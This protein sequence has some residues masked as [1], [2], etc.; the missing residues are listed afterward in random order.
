MQF[1]KEGYYSTMSLADAE[2]L[3][4]QVLKNVMEEKITKENVEIAVV[5][6]DNK[7][8]ET[9]KQDYVQGIIDTLS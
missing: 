4:L 5:K 8:L 7:V 1:I 3:V 6:T 2:K 9:R